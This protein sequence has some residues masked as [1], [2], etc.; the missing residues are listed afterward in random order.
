MTEEERRELIARQYRGLYG[1]GST[2]YSEGGQG[3]SSRSVSGD[4]RV[5]SGSGPGLRG[6]SP[7]TFGMN[8]PNKSTNPNVQMPARD[9][10]QNTSSGSDHRGNNN[11]SPSGNSVPGFGRFENAQQSGRASTSSP[12]NTSPPRN[13]PIQ[14]TTAP[15][16]TRPG[17]SAQAPGPAG[18]QKRSTTPLPS[19][20]SFGFSASGQSNP[21]TGERSTSASSNPSSAQD[22]GVSLGW[23][24]NGG[25]WGNSKGGL[26][27][28]QAS[29]WS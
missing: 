16:G 4:A 7:L 17:Q 10:E 12:N 22:K 11:P 1:E 29:V 24:N 2:L 9:N 23:N 5:T 28:V 14:S 13:G 20:L 15:I 19:P 26:G 25:V 21:Q 27:G 18:I 8:V 6:G 3:A